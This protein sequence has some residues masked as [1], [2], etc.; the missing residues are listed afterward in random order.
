MVQTIGLEAC[1]R[2]L[3]CLAAL[4]VLTVG[5]G[6][7]QVTTATF[8]GIVTDPTGAVI[9]NAAVTLTQEETGT[10]TSKVADSDG[11]FVFDFLHV[12][13]YTLEIKAAGFK[14]YAAGG[15]TLTASQRFR[16]TFKLEVGNVAET[17]N[18]EA[19]STQ[20]N[21]V[22]AEQRQALTRTEITEL[23]VAQRSFDN[24]LALGTGAQ[25]SSTGGVRLNG[26][27]RSGVKITVDGTDATSNPENA[28]TALKNNFNF[29]HVMSLEAIQEVETTKGVTPAEYGQ[30]LSGNVNLI[31]KSGTNQWHGSLFENF[32]GE[33]LNA[34]DRFLQ[35]RPGFTFNQFGGS[36][37][38]PIKRD[39]IFIFGTY[40][41]YRQ[42]SFNIV[43]GDVP[44]PQFRD[45]AIAAQPQ[46]KTFFDLI[47]LPNQ[48]Y[49]AGADTARY[50]GSGSERRH[51]N[52]AVLKSDIRVGAN[53]NLAVTYTRGRPFYETPQGRVMKV[54]DQTFQGWQERGTISYVTGGTRWTSETR[55][56]YNYNDTQ[57]VDG[58]WLLAPDSVA[59]Q[60][61]GGRLIPSVSLSGVFD[62]GGSAEFINNFGPVWSVEE[63]FARPVG[64]HS[65]KFGGIYTA[66]KPGRFDI[67]N[68]S[69]T[70]AN[71]ADF[72]ANIPNS[73]VNIFGTNRYFGHSHD[74]GGFAQDD[75]RIRSNLVLNLGIRYDYFSK[76]H[77]TPEVAGNPAGLYNPDGL[78]D[79]TF[80]F[81]P[82]RKPDDPI[83][84]DRW[85]NLGPRVGFSY[86]PGGKTV[87]RGGFGIM[88]GP[89]AWDDYNRAVSISPQLPFKVTFSRSDAVNLGVVY[90]AYNDAIRS[91]VLNNPGI[92]QIGYAF[93]PHIQS[94]YTGNVYLGVQRSITNTVMIESAF[95]G[96]KGEKFRMARMFNWPDRVTDV[97]PNPN[98]GQGVY[99]CSC[100]NTVYTSWQ[101]SL[102]KRYSKNLTFAGHYTWGK[103]LSYT[104]GDSGADFSGDTVNSIQD[105]F[106]PRG[107]RGPS[108]GD[109]THMFT[110]DWVY[111]FP[112]PGGLRSALAR[113]VLGGWE[114][115]GIFTARTGMPVYISQS[116]LYSRPDYVGGNPINPNYN[117]TGVY[118][119]L[120]AFAKVP[121]GKGG[122]PAYPGSL[123]NNAIR[124]TGL[125]NLDTSLA[126]NFRWRERARL[127]VRADFFNTFNHTGYSDWTASIN[128]ANFG[129]FT[130]FYPPRQMQ[131]NARLQW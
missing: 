115:S 69:I 57:R 93:D 66:R 126:K 102:R 114:I 95:V 60:N 62:N 12:G 111:T 106:N 104:G 84:S 129:K 54:N 127:Q 45:Q 13:A 121:L 63:K 124:G 125:W 81:G 64:A 33:A 74:I 101:T 82:I 87:I 37:G 103:G 8:Y 27:G 21:A 44:T 49:A 128:S 89:Q 25:L 15:I 18:V 85:V 79:S 29:I 92:Q 48:P 88:F 119:N 20:L 59:P 35:K 14:A 107:S 72:F 68:A 30:Q 116:G 19:Q 67:Q 78:L 96:N 16:G 7:A 55:Y 99:Y 65:F 38:G 26:I 97:R 58:L 50:L 34:T 73:T 6:R 51:D 94:P 98:L 100:Q 130:A 118:L 47:Y 17:V 3:V 105:F 32:R 108:T 86:S 71:K 110:G 131:L 36:A 90:P 56:G 5:A 53:G 4:M 10:S 11:E 80:H 117:N 77:A 113:H 43:Q 75:W 9:P 112:V 120:A 123:G 31:A 83:N 52:H 91:V 76:F 61:P 23:P 39:R 109:I 40:E 2:V 1:R 28:G 42:R 122:N 41:G 70:Y 24:I 22:S 46:Y